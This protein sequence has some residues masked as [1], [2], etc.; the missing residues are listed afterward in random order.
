MLLFLGVVIILCWTMGKVSCDPTVKNNYILVCSPCLSWRSWQSLKMFSSMDRPCHTNHPI[1][2]MGTCFALGGAD[3]LSEI[4]TF[5]RSRLSNLSSTPLEAR[6]KR[7]PLKIRSYVKSYVS[8]NQSVSYD[9]SSRI[10]WRECNT[11]LYLWIAACV[12]PT[13]RRHTFASKK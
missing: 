11:T 6:M 9:L 5:D 10:I 7:R 8:N 13:A 12:Q 2:I 1:I 4:K 3:I